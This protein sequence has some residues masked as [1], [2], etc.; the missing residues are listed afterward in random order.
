VSREEQKQVPNGKLARRHPK[1]IPNVKMASLQKV[2]TAIVS[3]IFAGN[4]QLAKDIV[5]PIIDNQQ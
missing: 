3:S 5:P 2:L 4:Q 1:V